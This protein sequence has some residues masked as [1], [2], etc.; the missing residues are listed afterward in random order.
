MFQENSD[1]SL[2]QAFHEEVIELYEFNYNIFNKISNLVGLGVLNLHFKI[3]FIGKI[4][5]SWVFYY[6]IA[7]IYT[8]FIDA[9]DVNLLLEDSTV[10]G[11]GFQVMSKY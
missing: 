5:L 2:Q 8:V 10:F 6:L 9:H 1:D 4:T 11:F 7:V 3:T